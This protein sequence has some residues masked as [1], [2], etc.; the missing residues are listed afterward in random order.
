MSNEQNERLKHRL[1][2]AVWQQ[3]AHH[4]EK[5]AP[6]R[7]PKDVQISVRISIAIP[8]KGGALPLAN[9]ISSC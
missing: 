3:G 8:L 7:A 9:D 1:R 5:I 4:D 2:K 6:C